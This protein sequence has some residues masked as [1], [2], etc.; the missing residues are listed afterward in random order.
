MSVCNY[1]LFFICL[2]F[3]VNFNL[4]FWRNIPT[5]LPSDVLT[6]RYC[7]SVRGGRKFPINPKNTKL[8]IICH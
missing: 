8:F 1:L 4:Y 5:Y 2:R 6:Q 3:I 7:I